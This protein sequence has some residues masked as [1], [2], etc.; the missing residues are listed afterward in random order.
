MINNP[1]YRG[2]IIFISLVVMFALPAIMAKT[3]LSQHWYQSGVTNKGEL[4][5][6]HSTLDSFG[7]TNPYQQQQWQLGYVIPDKCDEFCQQQIYL[8][9]QSHL[10]L[11]KYQQRVQPVLL[12]TPNSD[13]IEAPEGSYQRLEVNQEFAQVVGQFEF[14]IVD[15]LGQLVMRYP[16][17][18]SP[19]ELVPQSK[20]LLADLRKLL[21][22]SR[23]G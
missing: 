14:V 8:L 3:V 22:L 21:K 11:G 17:V 10:A 2:R 6:P 20:G 4:I 13:S 18:N 12:I 23:V 16:K 9:G 7:L 5:E 1:V 15:P 19:S